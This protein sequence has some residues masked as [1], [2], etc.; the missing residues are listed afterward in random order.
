MLK[1]PLVTNLKKRKNKRYDFYYNT[2]GPIIK[3]RRLELKKTQEDVACS[4]CSNTYISKAENNQVTIAKEQLSLIM[5]RLDIPDQAYANPEELVYYLERVIEYYFYRDISQYQKLMD[6]IDGYHFHALV[7]V[8]KLGYYV[9]VKDYQ[10]ALKIYQQLLDYLSALED[11]AFAVFLIF[12]ADLCLK[13]NEFQL[14]KFLIDSLDVIHM[15]YS[16]LLPMYLYSKFRIYGRLCLP[17]ESLRAY[18]QLVHILVDTGNIL[19]MNECM[20]CKNLFATMDGEGHQ[21]KYLESLINEIDPEV[22]DEYLVIKAFNSKNPEY[23]VSL[24]KNKQSEMYLVAL[25]VLARYYRKKKDE[26][27][28]QEMI[29]K[30]SEMRKTLDYEIDFN[31][32][33]ELKE[34]DQWIFYKEY[35]VNPCLKVAKTNE[36]IYMMRH[37]SQRIV[38]V[39]EKN[40]RYKDALNYTIQTDKRIHRLKFES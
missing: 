40:N 8:L 1:Q 10:S 29:E 17:R 5:E 24:I 18:N 32:L 4:I 33:L 16:E 2:Y 15:N 27:L 22:V 21:F 3:K 13:T 26:S 12:S 19:L 14:A 28:Y 11:L 30:I 9:L 35:L 37:I 36:N 6:K 23:Y 39:L 34:S 7:E 20:I 25:Y 31:H 38:D